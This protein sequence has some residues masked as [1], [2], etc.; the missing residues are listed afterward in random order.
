MYVKNVTPICKRGGKRDNQLLL[1]ICGKHFER[2]IFNSLYSFFKDN[3]FISSYQSGFVPGVSCVYQFIYLT[4]KTFHAFVLNPFL[5][6]RGIF[7]D[8]SKAFDK[9]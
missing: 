7:L 4:H 3:N 1:P 8:T 6:A 9:M 2:L 5:E